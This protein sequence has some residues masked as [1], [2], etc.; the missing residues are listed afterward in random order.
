MSTAQ[1][2]CAAGG[3]AEV[4]LTFAPDH[5]SDHFSDGVRIEL[6][7]QEEQHTFRVS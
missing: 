3:A 1:L 4:T 7:G 5:A 6:F 2:L